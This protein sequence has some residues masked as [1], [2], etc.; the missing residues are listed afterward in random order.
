M[1]TLQTIIGALVV[2]ALLYVAFIV[3]AV[4]IRILFGLLAIIV[5]GFLVRRLV[6]RSTDRSP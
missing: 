2:I 6:V 1:N 4:I 5:A 3:G